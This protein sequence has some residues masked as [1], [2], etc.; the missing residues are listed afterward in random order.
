M[1]RSVILGNNPKRK[2]ASGDTSIKRGLFEGNST[3]REAENF[4]GPKYTQSRTG[5]SDDVSSQEERKLRKKKY[6]EYKGK[7]S[8]RS[9]GV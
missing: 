4:P 2:P 5:A 1:H 6:R 7:E 3:E 8:F 9:I